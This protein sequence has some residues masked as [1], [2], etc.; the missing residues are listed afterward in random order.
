MGLRMLLATAAAALF[1]AAA[2]ALADT[3][4]VPPGDPCLK[5]NGNPCNGNNGNLGDQ[6]NSGH[7]H[8]TIDKKPPPIDLSMPAVSGRGAFITQIGD[9]N[10]ATV[11]QTAPNAY[12][13]V[14]QDGSGNE[15][16]ISQSG[17]GTGYI[18]LGQTGSANFAR[19]EQKGSGQ[20]VA[21]LTQSGT[22]NWAWVD[23]DATGAVYNAARLSQTGD[24]NDM[25]LYQDGTDNR[26]LLSQ[27]G[28]DNGMTAIQLGD[29]NRLTWI[30]QGD[31]LTDLEITQTGGAAKGGQLMVT[32]TGVGNGG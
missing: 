10:I 14:D 31:N 19:M 3:P 13:K 29:G 12:A 26:A 20:N 22:S 16:D 32:Q 6:G 18:E 27:E 28:D 7:E 21:Y 2:P 15:G 17:T 5:D 24:N 9:A 23:Q 1:V 4:S 25:L 8:T 11:R 30:Q